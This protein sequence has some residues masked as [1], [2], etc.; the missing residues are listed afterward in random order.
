[1]DSITT[2]NPIDATAQPPSPREQRRNLLTRVHE[3]LAA[4]NEALAAAREAEQTLTEAEQT[5]TTARAETVSRSKAVGVLLLE[6]K[7]LFPRAKDFDRFLK[8]VNGLQRSRAYDLMRLAGG[9]IT[10]EELKQEARDR[11]RKS[12]ALKLPKFAPEEARIRDR[13][14]VTDSPEIEKA[15]EPTAEQVA[16]TSAEYLDEFA[17]MARLYL[18]MVTIEADRQMARQIVLEL[19]TEPKAEAA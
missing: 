9:R 16:K 7:K 15:P 8:S 19:T 17:N 5:L 3:A 10:D 13:P 18:P 6:A 1:M 2:P 14:H 4:V 12:R 11:Q